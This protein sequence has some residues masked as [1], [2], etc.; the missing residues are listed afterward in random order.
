MRSVKSAARAM[1]L[2]E[3]FAE[4]KRPATGKEIG[5]ALRMPQSSTS[6][7][8]STLCAKGYLA[9]VDGGAFF[10]TV[11]VMLLG[12]WLRHELLDEADL[13]FAMDQVRRDTGQTVLIG[14]RQDLQV[15]IMFVLWGAKSSSVQIFPG[16]TYPVCKS[17][18]GK[19]LLSLEPDKEVERVA[20]RSNAVSP[21]DQVSVAGLLDEVRTCRMLGWAAAEDYPFTGR[22]AI[23]ALLPVLTGHPRMGI[24]LGVPMADLH[25]NRNAYLDTLATV[26][27]SL[28]PRL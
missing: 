1:D 14:T 28:T 22:G 2:F 10:P 3:F 9:Q 4:A 24:A 26:V 21:A 12:Q 5:A 19:M 25:Y 13:V 11:R 20:R 15:R 27:A 17:P 23:A 6:M 8:L 16:A 18:M 7:L